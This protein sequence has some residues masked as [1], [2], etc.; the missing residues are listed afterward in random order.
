MMTMD[1]SIEY[2]VNKKLAEIAQKLPTLV[3]DDPASFACGW[4]AGYKAAVLS[5]ERYLEDGGLKGIEERRAK[6]ANFGC[7]VMGD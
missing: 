2:W 1:K 6:Q 3:H 4:N 5:L 7:V